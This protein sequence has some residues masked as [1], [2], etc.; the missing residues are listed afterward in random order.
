MATKKR[1][2]GRGLD[3]LLGSKTNTKRDLS[4]T[5][6]D[7]D[8]ILTELE[9]ELIQPGK[10]QPRT[11]MDA[12]KLE[13]LAD[14]IKAQGMV[15]PVI[16]RSIGKNKYEIIAGERRW[17]AAQIAELSKVPV[18]IKQAD[19]RQ[20]IAMALIENIQ[21]EDLNPLEEALALQRLIEE[22]DLTHQQA[23]EAVGRSRVAVS[24]L[25][26]LLDLHKDVKKLLDDGQ[27]EMGHAR[28]LLALDKSLQLKAAMEMINKSMTVRAAEQFV[29][30][31]GAEKVQKTQSQKDSDIRK[32]EHDLSEKLCSQV[33]IQHSKQGKGKLVISYHSVDELEGILSRIK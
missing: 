29:K 4:V 17:R 6:S 28:T 12:Q 26:R 33:S 8:N 23:A 14:S 5:Q 10:Y 32:L 13:E 21:R 3:A 22:F 18:V 9:I 16:V 19:D 20:T 30:N 11:K 31:H 27:L 15:Q 25:L 2:L 24:N 7:N 1:G